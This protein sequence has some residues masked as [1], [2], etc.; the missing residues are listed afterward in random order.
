MRGAATGRRRS[1]LTALATAA[2][3]LPF[4]VLGDI[5]GI[6]ILHPMAVVVLGGL[7]TS[8]V[9]T[10]FVLPALYLPFGASAAGRGRATERR[11]SRPGPD[12]D[13]LPGT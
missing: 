11:R 5:A 4:A 10:L 12:L 1:L 2:V 8:T 9:L 7:V 13:L 6:E 3:L